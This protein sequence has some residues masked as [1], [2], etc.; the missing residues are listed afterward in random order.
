[1]DYWPWLVDRPHSDHDDLADRWTEGYQPIVRMNETYN[2]YKLLQRLDNYS[3]FTLQ[4]QTKEYMA[5]RFVDRV[6][7]EEDSSESRN[8]MLQEHQ[9]KRISDYI[10]RNCR[11]PRVLKIKDYFSV[12]HHQSQQPKYANIRFPA[13]VHQL[14]GVSLHE[15]MAKDRPSFK[16]REEYI[17]QVAHAV[18]SLHDIGVVLGGEL[19]D[20]YVKQKSYRVL[21][22][23]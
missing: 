6:I 11:N 12:P 21:I 20:I 8:E 14:T 17:N 1:M 22:L 23:N 13:I 19:V 3:W 15:H 9:E 5:V 4:P 2:G 18:A 7:P 10:T 16:K